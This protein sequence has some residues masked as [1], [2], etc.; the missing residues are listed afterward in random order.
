MRAKCPSVSGAP[1][2]VSSKAIANVNRVGL[3]P[4]GS[5]P[6]GAARLARRRT[7]G[8]PTSIN[9]RFAMRNELSAREME[10]AR[11]VACGLTHKQIACK[12]GTTAASVLRSLENVFQKLVIHNRT[13]LALLI[14]KNGESHDLPQ[15]DQRG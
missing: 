4:P 15:Y 7:G 12:L 11:L 9:R 10:I 1:P 3:A 6:R 5:G 8:S 14:I 2:T 13:M